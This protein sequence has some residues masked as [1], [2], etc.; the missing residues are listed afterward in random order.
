MKSFSKD[1]ALMLFFAV[2]LSFFAGLKAMKPEKAGS[3]EELNAAAR[4]KNYKLGMIQHIQKLM[5]LEAQIKAEILKSFDQSE[6]RNQYNRRSSL[7]GAV[8]N[9]VD[10][11]PEIVNEVQPERDAIVKAGEQIPAA[12]NWIED[13]AQ[14]ESIFEKTKLLLENGEALAHK[15]LALLKAKFNTLLIKPEE[16]VVA[17]QPIALSLSTAMPKDFAQEKTENELFAKYQPSQDSCRPSWRMGNDGKPAKGKSIIN[18]FEGG[19]ACMLKVDPIS[20]KSLKSLFFGN[21]AEFDK[22]APEIKALAQAKKIKI[23]KYCARELNSIVMFL[24]ESHI[25]ALLYIK[26]DL[27]SVINHYLDGYLLG[28]SDKDIEALYRAIPTLGDF[29]KDKNEALEWIAKNKLD[30]EEWA[31]KNILNYKK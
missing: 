10:L 27:E 17:S 21:F 9:L 7:V 18:S 6:I 30:I 20:G 31:R 12:R 28:Y 14:W 29:S 15:A 26:K 3:M 22:T 1:S 23:I 2:V 5:S 24:P 16:P 19:L 13:T 8:W 11:Y 4:I 25:N